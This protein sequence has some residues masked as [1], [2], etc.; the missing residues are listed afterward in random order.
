MRGEK[1]GRRN[2]GTY[3]PSLF[4]V[5]KKQMTSLSVKKQGREANR[6]RPRRELRRPCREGV[7]GVRA[8]GV[9]AG[10][11]VSGVR[12]RSKQGYPVS[13]VRKQGVNLSRLPFA[14]CAAPLYP[15]ARA[16]FPYRAHFPA[17]FSS[18]R[19]RRAPR[20]RL[21]DRQASGR[22]GIHVESTPGAA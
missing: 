1:Q 8:G 21:R 14:F 15:P 6:R 12:R 7:S 17:R 19:A 3:G 4:S 5:G 11:G 10:R 2:N 22:R 20:A 16:L 13:G 9:R 18:S